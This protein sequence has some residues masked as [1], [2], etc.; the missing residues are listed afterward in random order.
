MNLY[1]DISSG[2]NTRDSTPSRRPSS[3]APL[4]VRQVSTEREKHA[5]QSIEVEELFALLQ[6]DRREGEGKGEGEGEEGSP[7]MTQY[8]LL[9]PQP[10]SQSRAAASSFRSRSLSL[11]LPA[12]EEAPEHKRGATRAAPRVTMTRPA[13][14][15]TRAVSLPA[16]PLSPLLPALHPAP[17]SPRVPLAG[18]EGKAL[19]HS[20]AQAQAQAHVREDKTSRSVF[21]PLSHSPPSLASCADSLS[22]QRQQQRQHQHAHYPLAAASTPSPSPSPL[23]Q[24]HIRDMSRIF[25]HYSSHSSSSDQSYRGWRGAVRSQSGLA[26]SQDDEAEGRKN[27]SYSTDMGFDKHNRH[28]HSLNRK[29][30]LSPLAFIRKR[31]ASSASSFGISRSRGGPLLAEQD[32]G[33]EMKAGVEGERW[34]DRC[35]AMSG[36]HYQLAAW[37]SQR[38]RM[39]AESGERKEE[40]EESGGGKDRRGKKTSA[41]AVEKKE[42]YGDNVSIF[43]CVWCVCVFLN[44]RPTDVIYVVYYDDI[45]NFII[46]IYI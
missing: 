30:F 31:S 43:L 24:E 11:S 26:N 18:V 41:F 42:K 9:P 37:E 7:H 25:S 23:Q 14:P 13:R 19:L 3:R 29:N 40:G 20:Q 6:P 12:A 36:E 15:R 34:R 17:P 4:A 2:G 22:K 10:Q 33:A 27:R 44:N 28:R 16:A 8:H 45:L 39:R 46:Y 32:S 21:S 1:S 5:L 38:V 35:R